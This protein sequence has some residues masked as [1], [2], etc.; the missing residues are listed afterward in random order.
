MVESTS[1][2]TLW[3]FVASAPWAAGSGLWS[4]QSQAVNHDTV[5]HETMNRH[6]DDNSCNG[7][8]KGG[9]GGG[10][11]GGGGNG[12]DGGSGSIGGGGGDRQAIEGP[13]GDTDTA[14]TTPR[15]KLFQ[16][17]SNVNDEQAAANEGTSRGEGSRRI[18]A[19]TPELPPSDAG[20]RDLYSRH[21]RIAEA[22]ATEARALQKKEEQGRGRG[23]GG[24]EGGEWGGQG[25]CEDIELAMDAFK[26]LLEIDVDVGR[27]YGTGGVHK[28][29]HLGQ[30]NDDHW[31]EVQEVQMAVADNEGPLDETDIQLMVSRALGIR[32][33]GDSANRT[34]SRT[35]RESRGSRSSSQVSGW[36][37]RLDADSPH[38]ESRLRLRNVLRAFGSFNPGTRYCQGM[39]YSA[40][41]LLHVCNGDEAMA[42]QL[43]VLMTRRYGLDHLYS[44]GLPG[45]R[46]CFQVLSYFTRIHLPELSEHLA[47]QGVGVEMFTSSWFLTLFAN[48]DTLGPN[49][50]NAVLL[51]FLVDGWK[52]IYQAALTVL[53]AVQDVLLAGDLEAILTTMQYPR[54][55]LSR[56][57]GGGGGVCQTPADLFARAAKFKVTN[58]RVRDLE[59]R[60]RERGGSL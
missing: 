28:H 26:W 14:T 18:P 41:H 21:K 54:A 19:R 22:A 1:P 9:D 24:G 48:F 13:S 35:S 31:L 52:V 5:N 60:V 7:E 33:R 58:G 55:V 49:V 36:G 59:N 17:S 3:R 39:N 30:Q 15:T 4:M 38:Y 44:P 34:P 47:S 42:F 51:L 20:W 37:V 23:G 2:P 12:G 40:K 27:T 53:E 25:E 56:V 29:A 8:A 50:V 16:P 32:N 6:N 57:G 46:I 43:L 45:L 10:G 11:G